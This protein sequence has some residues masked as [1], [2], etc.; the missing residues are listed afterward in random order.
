MARLALG[1]HG[2]DIIVFSTNWVKECSPVPFWQKC[3]YLR[4]TARWHAAH[5]P[6]TLWL[7]P[8][9]HLPLYQRVALGLQSRDD[10]VND[11]PIE[12]DVLGRNICIRGDIPVQ[13]KIVV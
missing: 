12:F 1:S 9:F 3:G 10:G 6:S 5:R 4:T 2:V 7:L 13:S 11:N 8:I